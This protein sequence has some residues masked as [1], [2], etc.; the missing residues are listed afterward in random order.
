[1]S[2][3]RRLFA[4]RPVETIVAELN[5]APPLNRVLSASSLTAISVAAGLSI[6]GS[7]QCITISGNSAVQLM[8]VNSGAVSGRRFSSVKSRRR[9]TSLRNEVCPSTFFTRL[10]ERLR[11]SVHARPP[12]EI[13]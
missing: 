11:L 3:V 10:S 6:D 13:L 12:A 8:W 7:R 1:M 2:L 9:W 5:N 4:V